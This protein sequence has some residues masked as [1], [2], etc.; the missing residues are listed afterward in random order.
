MSENEVQVKWFL[1]NH[2]HFSLVSQTMLGAPQQDSDAMFAAVL[3][4]N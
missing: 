2:P 3:K 1:E 4:K